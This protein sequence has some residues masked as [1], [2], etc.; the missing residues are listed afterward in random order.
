[1]D[2][3]NKLGA[4]IKEARIDKGLSQEQL[5]EILNVTPTHIKHLESGRRKPSVNVL[6]QLSEI[7]SFSLDSLLEKNNFSEINP[8]AQRINAIIKN[9]NE[10]ELD[11]ITDVIKAIIKNI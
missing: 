2:I 3:D 5:A 4:V 9:C 11:T 7:L 6:F 10:K 8:K 1:M